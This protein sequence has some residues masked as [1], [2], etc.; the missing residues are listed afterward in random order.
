M[1][2]RGEAENGGG[3]ANAG[4][5]G[6]SGA[7]ASGGGILVS[8][9]GAATA[10]GAAKGEGAAS[11]YDDMPGFKKYGEFTQAASVYDPVSGR[12]LECW[13]SE[14][15]V[16]FYTATNVGPVMGKDGFK[17]G[18]YRAFCL[19]CQHLPDSPNRPEFPSTILRPGEEYRQ[20]TEFRFSVPEKPLEVGK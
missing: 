11:I 14:P 20:L 3:G 7:T 15:G 18:P 1:V 12:L 2:L 4:G 10:V 17:Y 13:T 19:E 6:A 16:H 8:A 5:S 9:A